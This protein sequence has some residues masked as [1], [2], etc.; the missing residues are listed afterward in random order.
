MLLPQSVEYALRA[1][2][3]IANQPEGTALRARDLSLAIGVP[4][5]YLSKVL[6]RLVLAG[7]LLSQRGRGGGFTLARPA[8]QVRF[9]DVMMAVDFRPD[10]D[11]CAFGWGAC[12]PSA[13]CPL[14]GA[15]SR[16]NEAVC[17]WA[18]QT[19]LADVDCDSA[20]M[21]GFRGAV[22]PAG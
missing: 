4:S 10:P 21:A 12:D 9:I 18:A 6:R 2:A 17:D 15:W 7:L 16:L 1:M 5:P 8:R 20:V 13:P 14:H 22:A 3:C 11:H 19:T